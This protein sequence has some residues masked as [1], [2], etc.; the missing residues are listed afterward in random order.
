V[1]LEE[2]EEDPVEED[3]EEEDLEEEDPEEE[4]LEEEDP[5]EEDLEEEDPEEE[6]LE[7][8][9]KDPEEEDPQDVNEENSLRRRRG[10]LNWIKMRIRI[11]HARKLARG[12]IGIK[13][14][15]RIISWIVMKLGAVQLELLV[16]HPLDR[17]HLIYQ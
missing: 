2:E 16:T 17:H 1:D 5:E 11:T 15:M 7:E 4:D 9:E 6:D 3:P 14:R 12:L 8:E 10:Q 13:W